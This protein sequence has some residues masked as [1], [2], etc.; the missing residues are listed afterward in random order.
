M[1][2]EESSAISGFCP[3]VC[4]SEV[5]IDRLTACPSRSPSMTIS[6]LLKAPSILHVSITIFP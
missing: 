4:S 6:P 2:A 1:R 5:S 3:V